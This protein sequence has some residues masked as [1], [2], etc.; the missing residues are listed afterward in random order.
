[1]N[2]LD[3]TEKKG[4]K[5]SE[6]EDVSMDLVLE[7]LKG[8]RQ[9]GDDVVTARCMI[10]AMKGNRQTMTAKEALRFNMAASVADEKQLKKYVTA[11]CPQ[12][13]KLLKA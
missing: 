8:N 3:I 1:M 7:Y 10:N 4:E 12:I 2:T 9:G 6:L 11:T 5:M 13:K